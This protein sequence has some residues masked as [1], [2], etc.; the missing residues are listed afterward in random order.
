MR[1]AVTRTGGFAGI[2]R[3]AELDTTGRHDEA[4]LR[5]LAV[6]ALSDGRPDR[7]AGVPDGFNYELEVDGIKAYCADPHL[8]APQRELIARVLGERA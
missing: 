2:T 7:P 4:R 6:A 3:R 8:S 5:S 1:I